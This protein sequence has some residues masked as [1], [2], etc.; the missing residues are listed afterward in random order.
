MWFRQESWL[1][2]RIGPNVG[3]YLLSFCCLVASGACLFTTWLVKKFGYKYLLIA[4]YSILCAFL[5]THLYPSIWL[6]LPAYAILGITLGPAWVCKWSLVVFF[7]SRISCGQH[8]CSTTVESGGS[9]EENKMVFCNRNE[10]V[11]RLA[12]WFHAIQDIGIFVGALAASIIISCAATESKCIFTQHLF[13]FSRD[14]SISNSSSGSSSSSGGNTNNLFSTTDIEKIPLN[15]LNDTHRGIDISHLS[16]VNFSNKSKALDGSVPPPSSPSL[17]LTKPPSGTIAA[18]DGD[19]NNE[20]TGYGLGILKFYQESI[21]SQ[22]DELLDSLFNTNEHGKS[23]ARLILDDSSCTVDEAT[24]DDACKIFLCRCSYLW[25]WI[26]SHVE[27]RIVCDKFH[28]RIQL[29]FHIFRHHSDDSFLFSTRAGRIDFSLSI[30]TR[31]QYVQMWKFKRHHWHTVVGFADGV[32]HRHRTGWVL[33]I[34][35]LSI[36]VFSN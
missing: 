13:K 24:H 18:I 7:A 28:G 25:Q 1:L 8:D 23:A 36:N 5:L 16:R 33:T 3:P 32:L 19:Y 34:F 11:R 27:L 2:K 20:S 10:R 15:T 29:V 21:F 17:P 31:W 4:H 30:A 35:L 22:H 6:L 14:N 9:G 26:V 12:R